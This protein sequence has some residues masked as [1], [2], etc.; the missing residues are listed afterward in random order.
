MSNRSDTFTRADSTSSL[1]TPS[2]GGS[3]WVAQ[4]GQWGI[5]T[6]RGYKFSDSNV[7]QHATLEASS[8]SVDVQVTVQTFRDGAGVIARVQNSQN[9]LNFHGFSGT[10]YRVY[11]VVANSWTQLGTTNA[12]TPASGDVYKLT[13]DGSNN[14]KGYIGGSLMVDAGA[15]SAGSTNTLHG[16]I[17]YVGD[18]TR[19]DDFSITDTAGAS[20]TSFSRRS[21][22]PL[23]ILN[24]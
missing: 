7:W 15:D 8:S 9:L 2:D 4:S 17:S 5:A 20:A 3:A 16:L 18:T 19:F 11:K 22:F 24:L 14:I 6:N 13:V 1:G 23:S 21:A 12:G 10:G